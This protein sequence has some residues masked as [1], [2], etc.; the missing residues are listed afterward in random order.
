VYH[1]E[2]D[3]SVENAKLVDHFVTGFEYKLAGHVVASGLPEYERPF[4]QLV[5]SRLTDEKRTNQQSGSR[6]GRNRQ[7]G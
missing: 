2:L 3:R 6:A 1:A 4:L 7:V 5:Q